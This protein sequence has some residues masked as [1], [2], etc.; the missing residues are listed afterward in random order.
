MKSA[1]IL[2]LGLALAMQSANAQGFTLTSSDIPAGGK[3]P[4]AQ[5]FNGM[6]CTG[7]NRSPAL[8]WKGAPANTKSFALTMYDP[9]AP[10]G[11]GWWHWVVYN[12]PAT[13][14]S[15]ATGAGDPTK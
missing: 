15:L 13:T 6:G 9:D 14:T 10:T 5:V 7:T 11:S 8:S 12:I 2:L 3:I 1:R 4:M